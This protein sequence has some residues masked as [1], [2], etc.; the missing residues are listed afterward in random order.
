VLL[1]GADGRFSV[2]RPTPVRFI[3]LRVS[4]RLLAPVV[5]G[6]DDRTMRVIPAGTEPLRLLTGYV[7]IIA[8][9]PGAISAEMAG[10][11]AAHLHDLIGLTLGG[12]RDAAAAATSLR[13][14]RLQAI[15]SDIV[16]RLGNGDLTVAAV[17]ARHRVTPRYVHKLF[18][19]D[20]TTFTRFVLAKRL[21]YAYRLL[22]NPRHSARSISAIAYDIG[23]GDLSYFNR[24]FRRRYGATPSDIRNDGGSLP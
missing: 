24:T 18:E 6:L 3:G 11:V 20:G 15:K 16:G 7:H 17:A 4:K 23:F 9:R 14:A 12:T 19:S 22:R 21:D 8:D 1:S 5:R 2:V 10:A 13:V